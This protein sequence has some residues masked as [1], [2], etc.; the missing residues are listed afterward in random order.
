EDDALINRKIHRSLGSSIQP[1][2]C[3]G[4]SLAQREEG[5]EM[6]FVE[7]QLRADLKDVEERDVPQIT[8]AYEP[9][10]AIG[11]GKTATPAQAQEMCAHIRGV[12]ARL[13]SAETAGRVT[14][15]YGGS[16]KPANI[17]EL[18][19]MEDIDG[20]LVGGASLDPQSFI[21]IVDYEKY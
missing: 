14:I 17:K 8:I 11:T 5:V 6:E 16:V 7:N 15:Q 10:W 21:K 13:Y 2:L 1:I 12:I 20:A 3:V 9:I 19:G 4:E 18:M